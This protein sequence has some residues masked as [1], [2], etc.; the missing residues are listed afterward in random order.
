MN[1]PTHAAAEENVVIRASSYLGGKTGEELEREFER[2]LGEGRRQFVIDFTDTEIINSIGISILI[3][4][5]ERIMER[6]GSLSFSNLSQVNEEIFNMMGLL[7]YA[8]LV[9]GRG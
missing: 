3:G 5:I 1:K 7:R 9:R 4:I 6:K 2:S 8:P